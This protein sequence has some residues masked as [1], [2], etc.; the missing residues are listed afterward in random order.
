MAAASSGSASARGAEKKRAWL[1]GAV[2][3]FM[4]RMPLYVLSSMGVSRV[5]R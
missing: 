5:D 2:W 3:S 1:V 4:I